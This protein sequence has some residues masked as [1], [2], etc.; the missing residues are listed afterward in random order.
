M[1]KKLS[2]VRQSNP[3]FKKNMVDD[4]IRQYADQME[5]GRLMICYQ[6]TNLLCYTM[7]C[8]IHWLY[9][10]GSWWPRYDEG[11]RDRAH[12]PSDYDDGEINNNNDDDDDWL[13]D[14][15]CI[16][17]SVDPL[18]IAAIQSSSSFEFSSSHSSSTPSSWSLSSVITLVHYSKKNIEGQVRWRSIPSPVT[19][20]AW[21][22]VVI[23][24]LKRRT[25]D[26]VATPH[27]SSSSGDGRV[28]RMVF[29]YKGA[30]EEVLDKHLVSILPF[31][32]STCYYH[33]N[34]SG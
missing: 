2:L 31:Y 30:P 33:M 10:A 9:T 17:I 7:L 15:F 18:E 26:D 27:G 5:L 6:S 14:L 28:V 21:V 8:Y 32:Y 20:S 1:R 11:D 16:I 22:S 24:D 4:Q 34:E 3:A 19:W 25:T 23:V 13:I 12:V 29:C